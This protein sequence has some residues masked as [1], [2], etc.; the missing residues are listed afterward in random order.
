VSPISAPTLPV[1]AFFRNS[2]PTEKEFMGR[3]V[4]E[5]VWFC[6]RYAQTGCQGVSSN[7]QS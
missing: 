2:E 4:R 6:V 3:S 7:R 1:G 5:T